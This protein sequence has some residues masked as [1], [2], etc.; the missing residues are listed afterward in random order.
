MSIQFS[1]NIQV[2]VY[3]YAF[4]RQFPVMTAKGVLTFVALTFF[5]Y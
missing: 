5:P 4:T 2:W 3:V 1:M